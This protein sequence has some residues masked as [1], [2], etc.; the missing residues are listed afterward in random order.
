MRLISV[1]VSLAKEVTY[2][3]QTVSTGIFKEPVGGRVMLRMLNLEGDRQADRTVHGGINK[4]VYA[5]PYEHYEYWSRELGR[6]DFSYGQF[7]E[8]FTV[9]GMLEDAVR[10]GD[11]FRVG[12]ARVEVTQPRSPCYKLG[13][14]MGMDSFPKT[15]LSSGRTG[16]YLKVL[17]EGDVGAGDPFE[18]V[19]GD[20]GGLSVRDI[21]RLAVQDRQ[22]LEGARKA[23]RLSTL[24]PEWRGRLEK[25]FKDAGIPFE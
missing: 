21:W 16:F 17:E 3:G 13:I 11:V 18:R 10:I 9:S 6:T 7:G 23:L 19:A 4:A 1:N 20:D 22:D 2:R 15:F 12:S 14:R 8:N 24:A 5:Y 25:R